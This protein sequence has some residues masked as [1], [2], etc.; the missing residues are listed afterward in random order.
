MDWTSILT[1]AGIAEPPGRPDAVIR[2]REATRR[3]LQRKHD[4]AAKPPAKPSPRR[5]ARRK[6]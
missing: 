2:A 5:T 3:R 4:P 1:K 6:P